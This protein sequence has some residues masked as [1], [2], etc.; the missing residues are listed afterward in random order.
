MWGCQECAAQGIKASFVS[1]VLGEEVFNGNTSPIPWLYFQSPET[2]EKIGGGI[3]VGSAPTL[4][5]V[6]QAPGRIWLG[7]I[8]A[9]V[10]K[11]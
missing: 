8:A 1:P 5:V 6:P 4:A 10:Q 9:C 3:L 11:A 2:S 7:I